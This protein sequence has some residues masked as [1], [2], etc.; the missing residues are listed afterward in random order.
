M[1]L[2]QETFGIATKYKTCVKQKGNTNCGQD[3][4]V[5]MYKGHGVYNKDLVIQRCLKHI[6]RA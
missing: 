4:A 1:K 5:S 3:T 2:I 6:V